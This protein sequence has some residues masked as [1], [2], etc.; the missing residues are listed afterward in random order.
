VLQGIGIDII[1]T[2]RFRTLQNTEAF[3]KTIFTPAEIK[4]GKQDPDPCPWWAQAFVCKE[5]ILKALSIGLFF[6]SFWHDISLDA[7]H[8]AVVTGI[9]Q[10]FLGSKNE[11][12]TARACSKRL[13][14]GCAII[15]HKEMA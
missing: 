6:G 3:L 7:D 4:Q 5:A 2:E 1:E 9:I 11:I 14:I 12:H 15:H 10:R 8:Q 13:A